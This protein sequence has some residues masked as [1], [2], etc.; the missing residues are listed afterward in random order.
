MCDSQTLFPFEILI[1]LLRSRP[2]CWWLTLQNDGKE[3]KG[4]DTVIEIAIFALNILCDF[5]VCV[6]LRAA[7]PQRMIS[8][9]E[10]TSIDGSP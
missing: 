5:G 8:D 9:Q 10:R 1:R 6:K 4:S 7:C 2:T 3:M